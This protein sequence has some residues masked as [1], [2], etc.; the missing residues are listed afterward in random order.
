MGASPTALS[1]SLWS[2]GPRG[3]TGLHG[4]EKAHDAPGRSSGFVLGGSAFPGPDPALS[5]V[6]L[7]AQWPGFPPIQERIPWIRVIARYGG[8]SAVEW[9]LGPCDNVSRG[10]AAF[11]TLPY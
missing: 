1:R 9:A 4:L 8:A 7:G 10:P 6:G 11:T 2:D 5:R 3:P